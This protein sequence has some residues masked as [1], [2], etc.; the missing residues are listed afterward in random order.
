MAMTKVMAGSM[1]L[2]AEAMVGDEYLSPMKYNNWFIVALHVKC[3]P[4]LISMLF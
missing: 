2:R 4:F 3:E 1:L